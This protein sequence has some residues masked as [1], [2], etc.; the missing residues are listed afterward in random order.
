MRQFGKSK[1]SIE[2]II[3]IVNAAAVCRRLFLWVM[4]MMMMM[5]QQLRQIEYTRVLDSQNLQCLS[6]HL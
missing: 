5:L 1:G 3:V 4:M 2:F 6:Q